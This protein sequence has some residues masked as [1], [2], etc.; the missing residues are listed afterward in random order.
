MLPKH[1]PRAY[2]TIDFPNNVIIGISRLL[3]TSKIPGINRT[4]FKLSISRLLEHPINF[5]YLALSQLLFSSTIQR[6]MSEYDNVVVGKLRLKGNALDV[7][8][9]GITKK[10]K[11]KKQYE[12]LFTNN[13]TSVQTYPNPIG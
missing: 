11:Q 13:N 2:H 8:S 9:G 10:K 4:L 1:F 12:Q 3:E 7:K 5:F 6:L